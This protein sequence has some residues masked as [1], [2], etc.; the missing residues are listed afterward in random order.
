MRIYNGG[1]GRKTKEVD[2]LIKAIEERVEVL[3]AKGNN[4]GLLAQIKTATNPQELAQTYKLLFGK[5]YVFTTPTS[6]KDLLSSAEDAEI[7][8]ETNEK[9]GEEVDNDPS[10]NRDSHPGYD[11]EPIDSTASDVKPGETPNP[12]KAPVVSRDYTQGD[13]SQAQTSEPV[14]NIPEPSGP[15]FELPK[16]QPTPGIADTKGK[17]E[18]VTPFANTGLKDMEAEQQ[19]KAAKMAANAAMLWFKKQQ[20]KPFQWFCKMDI[21]EE[22]LTEKAINGELDIDEQLQIGEETMITVNA[23][24]SDTRGRIDNSFQLDTETEKEIYEALV[25]VFMEQKIG[26]TPTQRLIAALAGLALTQIGQVVQFKRQISGALEVITE[27]YKGKMQVEKEKNE[28]Q[29]EEQRLRAAELELERA[30]VEALKVG[31]QEET[32][33]VK[34]KTKKTAEKAEK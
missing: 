21:T 3:K 33:A 4:D 19:K 11:D 17:T 10:D 29:R 27:N 13:P 34:D 12:F 7:L 26:L 15:D 30:K 25:D 2:R 24:F 18:P 14:N 5:E 6:K 1:L 8:S 28:L 22:K 9:L 20:H 23:L 16:D 31:K 32:K